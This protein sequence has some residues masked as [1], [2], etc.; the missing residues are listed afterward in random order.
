ML[1]SSIPFIFYFIPIFYLLFNV[2]GRKNSILLIGSMLFYIYGEGVYFLMLIILILI[3]FVG[4]GLVEK[5]SNRAS[6]VLLVLIIV[7]LGVL[8]FFKYFNFFIENLKL[9]T[10][11]SY[12]KQSNVELPLAISFFTFQLI[13]YVADVKKGLIKTEKKLIN[14][15]T[16]VFMFPHLIAGPIV[17]YADIR[18]EL[19]SFKA[20][21]APTLV[22]AVQYFIIGLCQKVLIANT[23]APVADFAFSVNPADLSFVDAW[24]G[25]VAYT[26]QI[27]FDFCGYSN[28][29]IGL[30]LSM[31]FVFPRNFNYPYASLSLTDFWRRWNVTLSLWF[32]DYVYIPLGGSRGTHLV[33]VR[34]LLI[35]FF[36]TG[37]WHGASWNFIV[38]GLFHGLFLLLE[39]Y[40]STIAIFNKTIPRFVKN[41][42]VVMIVI[43]GWV[44]FRSDSLLSAVKYLS[45]MFDPGPS[46][47]ISLKMRLLM[48]P[49]TSIAFIVGGIFS[50]GILPLLA[51]YFKFPIYVNIDSSLTPKR[52]ILQVHILPISL[53][54]FLFLTSVL[55]L[56]GQSLNPFLYFRF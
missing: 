1:F 36:L 13:S 6:F 24:L 14:F 32:R 10:G 38:W 42:Y 56:T 52:E 39:K 33:T 41:C 50:Y 23:L 15:A 21:T 54:L 44:F 28:M 11:S 16:Y 31:G 26:L 55:L 37:L 19:S 17:R 12:L 47:W 20:L 2:L 35:V 49:E 4:A 53:L 45:V 18:N 3:N 34:N 51:N 29:A 8:G 27:Y 48:T 7:N 22:L 5:Y 46:I 30:A 43:T 40:V 25:A 9:L